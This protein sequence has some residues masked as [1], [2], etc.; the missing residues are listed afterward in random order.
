MMYR[1]SIFGDN[2]FDNWMNF[3]FPDV[4]KELYG[5]SAK[6]IM[7]TDVKETE[8]AYEIDMD[9]PG[10]GKEEITVDL[11]KGY[12]KVSAAKSVD[13]DEQDQETKKYIRRE[14]YAGQMSRSFYVGDKVTVDDIHA[15]YTDGVLT[16]TVDKPDTK[17]V[18]E[19]RRI[20]IEG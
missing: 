11:D 19:S 8:Q 20:S 5:K 12:L 17:A 18:E 14:R 10:F 15:K 2:L 9:L 16:L 3:S 6:S 7:K 13:K 1:P 4:E